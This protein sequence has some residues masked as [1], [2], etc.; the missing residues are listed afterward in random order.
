MADREDAAPIKVSEDGK[1]V[2]MK[3][4]EQAQFTMA[5]EYAY[6]ASGSPPEIPPNATLVFAEH[7]SISDDSRTTF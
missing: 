7:T 6:G 5:P 2:T 4:G 3:V 1:G